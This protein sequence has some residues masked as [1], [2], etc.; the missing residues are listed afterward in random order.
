MRKAFTLVEMLVVIIVIPVV[1][2]VLFGLFNPV[3][4]DIPRLTRAV[5]ENTTLLNMLSEMQ[6]DIEKATGLPESFAGQQASDNVLLIESVD[7]VTYYR[8]E[9]GQVIKSELRKGQSEAW[10]AKRVWAL[11]NCGIA[12]KV[13]RQNSDGYAVEVTTHIRARLVR[14]Y[15]ETMANAHLYFVN[16]LGEACN[17]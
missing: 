9:G 10:Q 6:R 5:Q 13:W 11:P 7:G 8:L 16:A 14:K 2:V 12:W 15:K 3:I 1:S 4:T 17:Q